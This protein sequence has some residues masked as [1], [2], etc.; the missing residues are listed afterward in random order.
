MVAGM[1]IRDLKNILLLNT[2]KLSKATGIPVTT[3]SRILKGT[4]SYDVHNLTPICDF[5][6][7]RREDLYRK[8]FVFPDWRTLL[9]KMGKIHKPGSNAYNEI[10]NNP[11]RIIN[12]LRYRLIP[13][14]FLKHYRQVKD[15]IQFFESECNWKYNSSSTT[16]AL[17]NLIDDN[18]VESRKVTNSLFEYRE[19]SNI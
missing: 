1:R 11:P 12:A 5:F 14:G 2:N 16:N 6:N 18:L 3:L 9:S 13:D 7:I 4:E 19:R 8:D 10:F 15:I 17:N